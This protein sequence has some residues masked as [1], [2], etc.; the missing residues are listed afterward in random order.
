[1]RWD[2]AKATPPLQPLSYNAY[3]AANCYHALAARPE[4]DPKRVG[5]V[6][7]SYGGKW[8]LFASCLYDQF[9]CGVWSD[10]GIVFDEK[11]ANVNYWEPWY[12]GH[13]KDPQRK[14]G[15]PGEKNPRTGAYRRL[16]EA[17][18]DLHEL[19]AL[20]APRP[21]LVSGGSED[22][23]ARWKALNHSVAV[24]DLLGVQDRFGM[25][26]RKGPQPTDEAN[27]QVYRFLEPVLK[28]ADL[29][30]GR[31]RYGVRRGGR[32]RIY[33]GAGDDSC[34]A[35]RGTTSSSARPAPTWCPAVDAVFQES[36]VK[37]KAT[38]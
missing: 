14:A 12:L 30:R 8:A 10:P 5:V 11:R 35:G 20:M 24:N 3:V 31:E 34:T 1:M 9:A 28:Q 2:Y 36:P 4:V 25:Q 22:P 19:H 7:L 38:A 21:F 32:D 15:I 37:K 33:G 26:D 23:P 18:R 13:D 27:E 17:G 29:R 16:V 6:G